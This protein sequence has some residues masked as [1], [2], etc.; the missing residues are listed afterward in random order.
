MKTRLLI[1]TAFL[2]CFIQARAG[3]IFVEC[4]SFAEKGGWVLDQQFM[5]Q[6]GSPY[7]LAHGMGVPVQDAT[8]EISLP[9]KGKYYVYVRTYNWTSPWKKG[10]GP[11]KF[12]VYVN[13]R[14][15]TNIL[16]AEGDSWMWQEAGSVNVKDTK[17]TVSLHDLTGF[18]GR[19]DAIY[20]TTEEGELPPSDV[21]ALNAFR[22]N[23]LGLPNV[24]PSAGKYDLVVVGAGIAG[25]SAA[26]SAARL[27]CKVAL[28]N[29]RPVIGG[30]NSSEIRVHPGGLLG[31]EPYKELGGLQQEFC[32][33]KGG[34][35]QPPYV[36]EDQKKLDIINNEKNISLF[37]NYHLIGVTMDGNKI[38]TVVAK[39]IENSKELSFEGETFS[40]CTGDGTLGYL[41]GA[42]YRIGRESRDDFGESIAPEKADS[43]TLGVS[44]QWYSVETEKPTKFPVF[45]YGLDFNINSFQNVFM[46][47]W[48]WAAGQPVDKIHKM[49]YLRDYLFN[50]I[51][52]NWSFMKNEYP[53]I[54]KY[55]P[56]NQKYKT[57]QLGWVQ[58]I[59]G[60]RESRRLMGDYILSEQDV[61]KNIQHEDASFIISWGLESQQPDSAN[62]E[63]FP[64]G[65]FRIFSHIVPIYHYAAPYRCLYSRNIDNLFMA[66]RDISA[67]HV[68]L[69]SA[70]IMRATGMQGEVVGMAASLCKK[71]DATPREVYRLYLNE[72]KELMTKGVNK[73]GIPNT[74][75]YNLG[76]Y[77]KEP[78]VIQ[79]AE[80]IKVLY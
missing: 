77:L 25:I 32:P 54:P 40:D 28:I 72:L 57:R 74:Q 39:N 23:A 27:G 8:T 15:L 43:L 26:V 29:D 6:M 2:F 61:T 19:C 76:D 70:R 71:H 49:E 56:D 47:E 80:A 59:V 38:K 67:T 62:L 73:K 52:S 65:P 53:K 48:N 14:K 45:K 36:Y 78:P 3:N 33:V 79:K 37:L 41:A 17:V 55:Y 5:D 66:G 51:Y 42:D 24:A 68:A 1:L 35:A 46:G 16:G 7:L 22:R 10:T 18:E 13:G 4:E 12:C 9:E 21:Q 58:Y 64:G 30:N 75:T 44:V 50:V 63:H 60:K 11:G 69:G 31:V 20:F 34:N